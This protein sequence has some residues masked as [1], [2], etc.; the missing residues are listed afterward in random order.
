VAA[1]ARLACSL[2]DAP[3]PT[4]FTSE[5][6]IEDGDG[7]RRTWRHV[8]P[9]EADPRQGL[10]SAHAPMGMAL[11]GRAVGDEVEVYLPAGTIAYRVIAV[12]LAEVTEPS[13]APT[14]SGVGGP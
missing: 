3:V 13:S 11:M 12:R 8:G 4:A 5:E 2:E 1:C 10:V 14:G 9:D 6:T 7:L